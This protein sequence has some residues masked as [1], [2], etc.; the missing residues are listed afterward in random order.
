LLLGLTDKNILRRIKL[1]NMQLTQLKINEIWPLCLVHD[2]S[3][4]GFERVST[5]FEF[6]SPISKKGVRIS[7]DFE[8]TAPISKDLQHFSNGF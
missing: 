2:G 3:I 1:E 5:L 7:K 8:K 6:N 4:L